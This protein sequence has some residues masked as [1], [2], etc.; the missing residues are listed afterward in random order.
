MKPLL[1]WPALLS[2]SPLPAVLPYERAVWGKVHAADS[3]FRWIARSSDLE[4]AE[5][6]LKSQISLGAEE[7]PVTAQLWRN[8][9]GRCYAVGLY[10]SRAKDT[11]GRTDFLEKQVL[12][13]ERLPDRGRT[14]ELDIPAALGALLLLPRVAALGDVIWWGRSAGK[15]WSNPGFSLSIDPAAHEPLPVGKE[16]LAAAIERGVEALRGAV[17]EPQLAGLYDQILAR[18]RPACL[19]GLQP[20]LPP[21]ALGALLLPLPREL[22]DSLSLAGWIPLGA[23]PLDRTRGALGDPRPVSGPGC[24]AG[25]G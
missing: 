15:P 22:A 19:T 18:R 9:G 24:R 3:D 12:A 20:P 7:R 23:H 14:P 8:L 13:W 4:D 11:A 1:A 16:E 17:P 25:G 10:P 21:E 6:E 5:P 2:P